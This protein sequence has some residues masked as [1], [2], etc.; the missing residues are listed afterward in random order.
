[1]S[2]DIDRKLIYCAMCVCACVHCVCVCVRACVCV[3]TCARSRGFHVCSCV[4]AQCGV[5]RARYQPTPCEQESIYCK[6][7]S[8]LSSRPRASLPVRPITILY[9]R[10]ATLLPVLAPFRPFTP[11]HPPTLLHPLLCDFLL[12]GCLRW[13][14]GIGPATQDSVV[15]P[16]RSS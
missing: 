2:C 14:F 5:G 13:F 16:S 4:T 3:C 7:R 1:M 6:P 12:L 8:C 10:A 15:P 11:P 9:P